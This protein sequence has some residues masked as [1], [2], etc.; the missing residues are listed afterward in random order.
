MLQRYL[1]RTVQTILLAAESRAEVIRKFYIVLYERSD[2]KML[3]FDNCSFYYNEDTENDRPF[4]IGVKDRENSDDNVERWDMVSL[5]KDD[6]KK[7][8]ELLKKSFTD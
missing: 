5:S 3:L 4:V 7:I 8:Y 6:A 1:L 2:L